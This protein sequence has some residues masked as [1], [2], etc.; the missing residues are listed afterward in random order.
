MPEPSKGSEV[1]VDMD[2]LS[3]RDARADARWEGGGGEKCP[4]PAGVL[5]TDDAHGDPLER[6]SLVVRRKL[7][8]GPPARALDPPADAASTHLAG[9]KCPEI[10]AAF[11]HA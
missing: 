7:R 4:P 10:A 3:S 2:T 5:G 8:M 6:G 1:S 11:A 9:W